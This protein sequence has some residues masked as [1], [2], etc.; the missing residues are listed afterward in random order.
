MIHLNPEF[1]RVFYYRGLSYAEQ[2]QHQLAIADYTKAI[3][4]NPEQTAVNLA[5]SQGKSQL[6]YDALNQLRRLQRSQ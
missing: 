6:K 4:I 2:E 5:Q 1:K 3:K